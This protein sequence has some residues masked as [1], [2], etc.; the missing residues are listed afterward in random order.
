VIQAARPWISSRDIDRGALWF[1]EISEQLSD[2]RTGIVCLT[3]ANQTT[4]WILFEAGA[5]A[6]GLTSSR[7]CTLLVDLQPTDIE[8]PL[9][10]FN[11]TFPTKSSMWAL[12][13]TLNGALAAQAL[14]ERILDT[15]FETYW[16]QFEQKFKLGLDGTIESAPQP[17][18]EDSLLK[19]ILSNTRKLAGK[20]REI[21]NRFPAS[22]DPG[23]K[24]KYRRLPTPAEFAR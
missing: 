9:A 17:R 18:S 20:V 10:Q 22:T 12:V 11:H 13:R 2:T 15:V 16:P 14:D 8:G 23:T 5:L 24:E 4:P 21:E 7:V 3:A 1:S 19:E 6:K